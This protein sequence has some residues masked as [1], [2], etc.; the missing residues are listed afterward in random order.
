MSIVKRLIENP[1]R[2]FN[3]LNKWRMLGWVSDE[4]YLK[5]I[6]RARLGK[7]L[8]LQNPKTF[9]EKIQWMKL[10]CR[11]QQPG[12]LTDKY[13]VKKYVADRVGER[14]LIPTIGIW[15]SF[16]AI[17]FE[18]LPKQFVLKC[19]HDSGT[20]VVCRDKNKLDR[21]NIR[22]RFENA[23]RRNYYTEGREISYKYIEPRIMAE[24][25]VQDMASAN[26]TVYKIMCFGGEPKLIKVICDDH[27][28]TQTIDFM[29]TDWKKVRLKQNFPNR[30]GELPKPR[31]LDEMLSVAKELSKDFAYLRVDLYEA[32]E[33]IY[34]SEISFFSDSGFAPFYPEEWDEKLGGWVHLNGKN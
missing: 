7:K 18:S 34:F 26:L 14:Y 15:N 24:E 3:V 30:D 28:D 20:V 33:K 1:Y 29:D 5:I 6:Y 2:V 16:D 32:G 4:I 23:L 21:D 27:T 11:E 13:L 17:D 9:N 31:K 19:T 10:H 12:F 22:K 25:Y 8:N